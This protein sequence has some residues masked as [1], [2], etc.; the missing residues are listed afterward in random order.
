MCK[1][2]FCSLSLFIH[3][4][5]LQNGRML[6]VLI[7]ANVNAQILILYAYTY[8][9]VHD[10]C[11]RIFTREQSPPLQPTTLRVYTFKHTPIQ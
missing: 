4:F 9:C 2:F 1:N 8:T 7:Y 11:F 5:P 3:T 10:V 6:Q